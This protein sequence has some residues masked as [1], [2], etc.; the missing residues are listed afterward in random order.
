MPECIFFLIRLIKYIF[1]V[2]VCLVRLLQAGEDSHLR[3]AQAQQVSSG[4]IYSNY[5][6]LEARASGTFF[7]NHCWFATI[8]LNDHLL[9]QTLFID[10]DGKTPPLKFC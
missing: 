4:L 9:A 10:A 8:A 1:K 6:P 2:C 3:A 5:S 7:L